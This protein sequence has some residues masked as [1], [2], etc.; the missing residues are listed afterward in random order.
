MNSKYHRLNAGANNSGAN[1]KLICTRGGLLEDADGNT[2]GDLVEMQQTP[3]FT[4]NNPGSGGIQNHLMPMSHIH[5][6]Q[7]QQ[8]QP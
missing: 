5:P 7:R 1:Q 2:M 8:K 6:P 4:H 3:N